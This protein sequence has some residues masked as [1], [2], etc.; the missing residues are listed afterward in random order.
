MQS[1][2]A[3]SLPQKNRAANAVARHWLLFV[4][5]V[6]LLTAHLLPVPH[7]GTLAG[8]PTI[9]AF[10]TF[11]G[12]PCPGCG[13]TR[14][15]IL[16]A[17]GDWSQAFVFHP[18]GISFYFGLW[19]ALALGVLPLLRGRVHPK[20]FFSQR[21]ILFASGAYAAAMIIIWLIRLSGIVPYP[22]HF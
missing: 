19:G 10:K 1:P 18:L 11:T 3:I 20:R 14:S 17:H 7:N 5:G 15:V 16:C 13:L 2:N 9:C 22:P 12:W 8:L 21:G 6:L 4:P